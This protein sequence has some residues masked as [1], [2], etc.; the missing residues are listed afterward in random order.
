ME[1]ISSDFPLIETNE[2]AE[3]I[4]KGTP[5]LTIVDANFK[6]EE[7]D[8]TFKKERIPGARYI[9]IRDIGDKS[10]E[11][12]NMLPTPEKFH[13]LLQDLDIGVNDHVVCYGDDMIVGATRAYWMFKTY[14]FP[15]VHVLNG[16]FQKWKKEGH[17]VETGEESWKQN[18]RKR[19]EE[20]FKFQLNS[21]NIAYMR[22]VKRIVGDK[23]EGYELI[24]ARPAKDFEGEQGTKSGHMPGAKNIPSSDVLQEFEAFKSKDEILETL[25]KHGVDLSKKVRT[26]CRTGMAA[27]VLYVA[28]KIVGTKDLALYDGSWTEWSKYEDN[29]VE[30]GATGSK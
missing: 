8:N 12:P 26:T 16:T 1:Q 6:G 23:C 19:T 15:N 9:H 28:S 11:L 27:S 2:L 24:D 25:K 29:P 21:C 13:A 4:K 10:N 3:L 22:D 30:Y 7:F 5:D 20:D 18:R 17:P 14:G